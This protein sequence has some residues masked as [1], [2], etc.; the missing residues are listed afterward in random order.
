MT[1]RRIVWSTRVSQQC[2]AG[3]LIKFSVVAAG[4][5]DRDQDPLSSV[6]RV[7]CIA[8]GETSVLNIAASIR[9]LLASG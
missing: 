3:H 2:I 7:P 8:V 4:R 6:C 5:G 9:P 1:S